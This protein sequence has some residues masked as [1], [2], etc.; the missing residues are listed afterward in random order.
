MWCLI[1]LCDSLFTK[2]YVDGLSRF[3]HTHIHTHNTHTHKLYNSFFFCVLLKKQCQ[4]EERILLFLR[5]TQNYVS[6]YNCAD[7]RYSEQ[8][9]QQSTCTY[10]SFI[11]AKL[12]YIL[13]HQAFRRSHWSWKKDEKT[14]S[15]AK[16]C[17]QMCETFCWLASRL[18]R[19]NCSEQSIS[20][21][22]TKKDIGVNKMGKPA[23]HKENNEWP[24]ISWLDFPG[25]GTG[26]ETDSGNKKANWDD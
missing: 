10:L 7:I 19:W 5:D 13:K 26:E 1:F 11:A 16:T 14:P 24:A 22:K 20:L 15:V 3:T 21:T 23:I 8:L 9:H 4:S 17:L 2:I 25:K 18:I 12:S 6:W